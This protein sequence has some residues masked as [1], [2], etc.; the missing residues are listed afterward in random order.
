MNDELFAAADSVARLARIL[1]RA[2]APLS[3]ADFRVL[4]AVEQGEDRASRLAQRLAVGKPAISATVESLAKRGLIERAKV[5]GDQRAMALAL[6][7]QGAV[8][9]AQAKRRLT[10]RVSEVADATADPAA[11]IGALAQLGPAVER[12]RAGVEAAAAERAEVRA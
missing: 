2:A 1:E 7:P 10:E 6:T 12:W 5:A 9:F 11:T 3:L 8:E 4:S